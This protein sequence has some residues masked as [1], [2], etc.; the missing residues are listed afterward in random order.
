MD[1]VN[2]FHIASKVCPSKFVLKISQVEEYLHFT[3]DGDET[4]TLITL[5]VISF[6]HLFLKMIY[7]N[8]MHI[9]L[10]SPM[11]YVM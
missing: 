7:E 5:E 1:R 11:T 10:L 6:S 4:Y 2:K 3:E 8:P 9:T